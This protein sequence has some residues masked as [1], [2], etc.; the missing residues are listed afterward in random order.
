MAERVLRA[1]LGNTKCTGSR[2][3]TGSHAVMA[4]GYDDAA[5]HFIILNSWGDKFGDKG[6]FYMPYDFIV[7]P[8]NCHDFWKIEFAERQYHD[9]RYS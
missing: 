5:R 3:A 8:K 1:E 7:D 4:V 9:Q 6:Y 2:L